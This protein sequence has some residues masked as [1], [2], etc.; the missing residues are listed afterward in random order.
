MCAEVPTSRTPAIKLAD[1]RTEGAL[2]NW[3]RSRRSSPGPLFN[4]GKVT[5]I[6]PEWVIWMACDV[7]A[8]LSSNETS[9]E[10]RSDIQGVSQAGPA[11]PTASANDQDLAW[12]LEALNR[13]GSRSRRTSRA[14]EPRTAPLCRGRR[15]A[16]LPRSP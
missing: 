12:F 6:H 9:H 7:F 13:G 2:A 15:L 4:G 14:P 16:R 5:E 1:F 3:R 10:A 11:R 8:Y